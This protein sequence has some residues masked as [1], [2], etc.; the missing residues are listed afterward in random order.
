MSTTS[1]AACCSKRSAKKSKFRTPFNFKV[2][3]GREWASKRQ[4][5]ASGESW[6]AAAVSGLLVGVARHWNGSAYSSIHYG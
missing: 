2:K 6:F 3:G 5:R 1:P 4:A